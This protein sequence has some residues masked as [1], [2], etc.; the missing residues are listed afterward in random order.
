MTAS[1][2]DRTH[3]PKDAGRRPFCVGWGT[4]VPSV[5]PHTVGVA[6]SGSHS[7]LGARQARL[8][9]VERA[10]HGAKR[11]YPSAKQFYLYTS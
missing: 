8:S 4:G 1:I 7:P 3:N 6:E 2:K 11:S 5:A 10:N 9:G